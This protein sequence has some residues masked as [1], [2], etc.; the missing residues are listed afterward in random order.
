MVSWAKNIEGPWSKPAAL[1]IDPPVTLSISISLYL[2]P[3][4]SLVR[5]CSHT[6]ARA[7]G[8]LT[9][10]PSSHRALLHRAQQRGHQTLAQATL[11]R[12][13]SRMCVRPEHSI[14]PLVCTRDVQRYWVELPLDPAASATTDD[15][16]AGV[17]AAAAATHTRTHTH[18]AR[19][20]W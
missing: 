19:C 8:A 2:S 4:L 14:L 12:T 16:A 10:F 5:A 6:R 1:Q 9:H 3:S 17:A 18:R 20:F 13:S 11:Q 15:F 7:R